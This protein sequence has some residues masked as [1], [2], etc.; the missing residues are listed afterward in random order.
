M[1]IEGKT[2]YEDEKIDLSITNNVVGNLPRSFIAGLDLPAP[3]PHAPLVV[4]VLLAL[5]P[6]AGTWTKRISYHYEQCRAGPV[7]VATVCNGFKPNRKLFGRSFD[8]TDWRSSGAA[9]PGSC[10]SAGA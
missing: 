5:G 6:I 4:R 8:F 3:Q 10:G 9:P 7:L 2:K 1:Y